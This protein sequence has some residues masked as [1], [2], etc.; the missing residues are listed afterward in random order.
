MLALGVG[1][2]RAGGFEVGLVHEDLA[3]TVGRD[4]VESGVQ[5]FG[6]PMIALDSSGAEQPADHLGLYLVCTLNARGVADYVLSSRRPSAFRACTS[7][8][9]GV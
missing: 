4:P 8:Y 7:D 5:L 9:A 1:E 3:W 6:N 2:Q